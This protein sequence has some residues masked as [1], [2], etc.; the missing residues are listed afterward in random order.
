MVRYLLN[1]NCF[2]IQNFIQNIYHLINNN[3]QDK[4]YFFNLK[5]YLKYFENDDK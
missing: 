1:L 3:F 2:L 5:K 4:N